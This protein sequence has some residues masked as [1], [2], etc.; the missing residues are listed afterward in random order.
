V[1]AH[2]AE[3]ERAANPLSLKESEFEEPRRLGREVKELKVEKEILREAASFF[4]V[5]GNR[6]R[7]GRRCDVWSTLAAPEGS[8]AWVRAWH[9]VL[10]LR[11]A[12]R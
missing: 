4:A 5:S 1:H 6:Q 12:V 7:G 3:Q 11:L 2:L 10:G 8:R 9:G